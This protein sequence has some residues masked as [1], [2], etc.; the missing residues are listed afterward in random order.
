MRLKIIT[1]M[2]RISVEYAINYSC[3]IGTGPL[4]E[5][6]GMII[7]LQCNLRV[8]EVK[9]VRRTQRYEID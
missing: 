4:I 5:N 6:T 9:E 2:E 3:N 1:S 8:I 7:Q